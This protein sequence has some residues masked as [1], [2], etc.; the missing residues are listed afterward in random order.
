[1][2]LLG[3]DWGESKIGLAY[4]DGIL[5]EPWGIIETK[6]W[7]TGIPRICKEQ[8]IERIVVGFSEGK[9]GEAQKLFVEEL[10]RMTNLP[11][12]LEDETLTT[13][14]AIAKMR[15]IGKTVKDEDAISAALILQ[16]YLDKL[17]DV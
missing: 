8:K 15:E 9:T 3:V 5:S 14:E 12:D 16:A 7:K 1:M 10:Q 17:E 13:Y 2:R 4:S 11:V 6:N